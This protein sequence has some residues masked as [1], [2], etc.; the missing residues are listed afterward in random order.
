MEAASRSAPWRGQGLLA[1]R[2]EGRKIAPDQRLR[3]RDLR[4]LAGEA[5]PRLG[6][7]RADEEPRQIVAR[8]RLGELAHQRQAARAEERAEEAGLVFAAR[9]RRAAPDAEGERGPRRLQ[10]SGAG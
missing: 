6:D 1:Q 9:R 8:V 2:V 5:A 4:V 10:R 3:A 7:F